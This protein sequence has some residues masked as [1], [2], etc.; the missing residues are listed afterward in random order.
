M[1]IMPGSCL[2]LRLYTIECFLVCL[3]EGYGIGVDTLLIV[4][5]PVL[6]LLIIM[7]LSWSIENEKSFF[8]WSS[9]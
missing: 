7:P 1:S 2:L 8:S 9:Y 4:S 6:A 3:F 5:V